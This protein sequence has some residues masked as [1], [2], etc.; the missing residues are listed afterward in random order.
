[1]AFLKKQPLKP[2][3]DVCSKV[4]VQL[5]GQSNF[6]KYFYF[7]FTQEI[8]MEMQ[9]HGHDPVLFHDIQVLYC[10]VNPDTHNTYNFFMGN[11]DVWYFC[12]LMY[13]RKAKVR[14]V[15]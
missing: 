2:R 4:A 5:P 11:T 7:N 13:F 6:D 12:T 15:L 14:V 10:C 8:Q 9:K 3:M 1:M